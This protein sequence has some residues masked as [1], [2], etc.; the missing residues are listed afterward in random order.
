MSNEVN[1]FEAKAYKRLYEL[2]RSTLLHII[3]MARTCV[4]TQKENSDEYRKI[5]EFIADIDKWDYCGIQSKT[6]TKIIDELEK[7]LGV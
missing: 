4:Q 1:Q 7:C 5:I 6:T 3:H 2:N